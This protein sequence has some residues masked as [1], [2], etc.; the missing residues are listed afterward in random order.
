MTGHDETGDR[1]GG[2]TGTRQR[3]D[4]DTTEDRT[5]D[6]TGQDRTGQARTEARTCDR[7]PG[8]WCQD[9]G[10]RIGQGTRQGH[11][12]PCNLYKASNNDSV[13]Q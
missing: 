12:K 8:I 6:R 10:Q 2:R 13:I 9:R 3:Q 5:G 4:R 11:G 1:T 7:E